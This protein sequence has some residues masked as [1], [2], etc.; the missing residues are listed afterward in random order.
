[1][2]GSNEVAMLDRH[3]IALLD[4]RVLQIAVRARANCGLRRPQVVVAGEALGLEAALGRVEYNGILE[5]LV[6]RLVES[7]GS[8]L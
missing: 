3:V 1:M 8:L 2:I 5:V 4:E 7:L 6:P